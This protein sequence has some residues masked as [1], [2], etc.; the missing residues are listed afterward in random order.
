[1]IILLCA[2]PLQ[3]QWGSGGLAQPPIP[4]FLASTARA[5]FWSVR[6]SPLGDYGDY[7]YDAVRRPEADEVWIPGVAGDGVVV[8]GPNEA[9]PAR[10]PDGSAI[11]VQ[12]TLGSRLWQLA[13]DPL[14]GGCLL[15]TNR[16]QDMVHLL[17]PQALLLERSVPVGDDPWGLDVD[18]PYAVVNCE[19]S[20]DVWL[21]DLES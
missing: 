12:I 3:A 20:G 18:W 16:G 5:S 21:I 13:I 9:G 19:D 6:S 4:P 11:T 2:T 10:D 17:A 14:Q 8:I 1:M 15:V 7:P